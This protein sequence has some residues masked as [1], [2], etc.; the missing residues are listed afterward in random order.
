M[1]FSTIY[2]YRSAGM[3][4]VLWTEPIVRAL[5]ARYEKVVLYTLFTDLFDNYPLQNVR[6]RRIPGGL[7][8]SWLKLLNR[9]S[10]NRTYHKLDGI[11]EASPKMHMLH[12]YQRYFNL[13]ITNEYPRLYLSREEQQ[14]VPGLP[15]KYMVLHLEPNAPLNYR[16]VYGVD[17]EEVVS[18]IRAKGIEVIITGTNPEPLKGATAFKGSLRELIRLI[19]HA[20]FFMG[21]DSGP[22]HIAASLGKPAL[23][24]FGSVNP[25]FRHF[26]GLFKGVILQQPCEFAGC[27]HE[28][29]SG[30]GQ[31]CKL[32]GDAGIPKCC[33][34]TTAGVISHVESFTDL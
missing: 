21:V 33:I 2:L 15:S 17:W 14:P 11:Y 28:V 23:L 29:V 8:R 18:H 19:N 30:K 27:Y 10:G 20:Q 31:P 5:A 13:P 12:A 4:D 22:S 3:G 32:V 6:V 9:F 1:K 26:F 24:F 25:D 16:K 7:K 34:H